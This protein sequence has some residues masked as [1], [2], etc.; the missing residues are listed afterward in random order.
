M[1]NKETQIQP[2]ALQVKQEQDEK[3]IEISYKLS[4]YKDRFKK[5]NIDK[6]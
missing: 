1:S 3:I 6:T 4:T 2:L 5:L